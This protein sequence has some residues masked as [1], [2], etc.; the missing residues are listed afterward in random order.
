MNRISNSGALQQ[1]LCNHPSVASGQQ[2]DAASSLCQFWAIL[3]ILSPPTYAQKDHWMRLQ[4]FQGKE[5]CQAQL[6]AWPS[7][8]Q[9]LCS[10]KVFW[11][12]AQSWLVSPQSARRDQDSHYRL[13]NGIVWLF[14]GTENNSLEMFFAISSVNNNKESLA[15]QHWV[16]AEGPKYSHHYP[17]YTVSLRVGIQAICPPFFFH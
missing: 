13:S 3:P 2:W 15:R 11:E 17:P 8:W 1:N 7:A 14:P 4:S 6:C 5:S 12:P 10:K 16:W 9:V